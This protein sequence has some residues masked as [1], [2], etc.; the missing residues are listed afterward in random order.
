MDWASFLQSLANGILIAGLYAAVTLG[1]TLVLGVMGIINFAHG[2]MV[3]LGAYNTFWLF[4]L[5]GIDPLLSIAM[6]GLLL[7]FIGL[8]L[9]RFTIRPIL[10]DPP[11]NQL[12]LTLGLSIFL[13]N[14]AMILWKADSRAV[15]TSYS[16][17]SLHLG[18]VHVGLT[19]LITFLIAVVLTVFLVLFLYKARPGRAMRA[20]SE[21]N[22]ASWLIGIN[23][24]K[25]YMLAFGVAAALAGASGALVSIIMYTFPMVGFKL[26]LKAFCILI[27]G[28][29]GNILGALFGSLILGLTESFVGTYVSEGSGWAEGI[30]FM[31]IM[32]ILIIK[33]TG[34]GGTRRE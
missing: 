5:F 8:F 9:Y 17:I 16:G 23:V 1:L 22:T 4:T 13:Q 10:R 28:G 24:Q 30:S 18:M 15:I 32:I 14:L 34:L 3:M 12:L 11:L 2:E 25:T 6:S 29:L 27:L 21:N 7:F 31:L 33:P 20:V 19:R 26:C